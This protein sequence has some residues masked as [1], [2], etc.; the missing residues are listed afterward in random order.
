MVK[1][2]YT[3]A[4]TFRRGLR[5]GIPICL[6]YLSVSFTFGMM[7]T[8]G[9]LPVW[10]S[11][12]ISMTN[13]TSAGQFAGTAIIIATGSLIE[14]AVTTFI[15]NIRY[16]LMSLSLSQKIDPQ[17]SLGARFA[18]AFGITDEIFA[19]SMQQTGRVNARYFTGLILMPYCGW[20]L[21]TFLGAGA[22]GL[23][24]EAIRGALGIA[25]Y[26][27]FLAIIIPPARK[28]KAILFTIAFSAALSCI[29]H[30]VPFI[31]QLSAGW[32]IIICAVVS[33]MLSAVLFP[34]KEEEEVGQ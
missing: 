20:A 18:I 2:V 26:G 31:N 12:L 21:G 9:G 27:M 28:S 6:G 19:V 16:M 25:I 30:Y 1:E 11:V 8:N 7:A 3:L 23:L 34:V 13:L 4:M 10:L 5:D 17:M 32:V 14:L 33:S 22:A 29:F 24:P 15:I